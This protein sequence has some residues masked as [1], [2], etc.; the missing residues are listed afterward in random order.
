MAFFQQQ[1]NLFS[2]YIRLVFQQLPLLLLLSC[3]QPPIACDNS[4]FLTSFFFFE[5]II[6]ALCAP[7]FFFCFFQFRLTL[8][9]LI[10]FVLWFS[11]LH[12]T[13][14]SMAFCEAQEAYF[15]LYL[16]I[17]FITLI[18]KL[19]S[20]LFGLFSCSLI[21]LVFFSRR[22]HFAMSGRLFYW[23]LSGDYLFTE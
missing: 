7:V 17:W 13:Y 21:V 2:M 4:N 20:I 1:A 15:P 6:A 22:Y 11:L 23:C 14:Q 16:I 9:I 12:S 5:Y 18:N 19:I 10:F 3:G 8:C